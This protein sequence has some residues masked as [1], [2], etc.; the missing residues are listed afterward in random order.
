MKK[1]GNPIGEV[2]LPSNVMNSKS[3]IFNKSQNYKK[4]KVL[5]IQKI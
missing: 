4:G 5:R 2:D 1:E 3:S